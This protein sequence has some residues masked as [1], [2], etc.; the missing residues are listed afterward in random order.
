M[1]VV[2][3]LP[4][5]SKAHLRAFNRCRIFFG[6]VHVSELGSADGASI[7]QDVCWE[8]SRVRMSP[9]LWPYQPRSGPTSFRVWQRLLATAFLRGHRRKVSAQTRDLLLCPPL[10]RWLPTSTAFRCHWTSFYSASANTLFLVAE[11]DATYTCHPA[12]NI[13]RRPKHPVRAFDDN[14]SSHVTTLPVDAVPVDC[15]EEP[16]K[17]VIPVSVPS[18]APS[19]E[20]PPYA[21]TWTAYV[22][23]LPSWEQDLLASITFVDRR[24]L[25][26]ALRLN[27]C[28]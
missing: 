17:I 25:L 9:L 4:D 6:V 3:S 15:T 8:G 2:L 19:A 26:V 28:I 18:L 23:T 7:S 24:S 20:P 11:A 27:E 21:A 16:D 14:H 13:R 12:R 5:V 22:A 1:D 10:G